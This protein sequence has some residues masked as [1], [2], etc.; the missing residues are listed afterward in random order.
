[1]DTQEIELNLDN[2]HILTNDYHR[3]VIRSVLLNE[4]FDRIFY[5]HKPKQM[6]V[7]RF[8]ELHGAYQGQSEYKVNHKNLT[9]YI[10]AN[11]MFDNK[12]GS[13]LDNV[14]KD[15]LNKRADT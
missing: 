9:Y 7:F 13:Y 3:E 6:S 2:L 14:A 4:K 10:M 8:V 11:I 1:V 12:K 5:T 15:F